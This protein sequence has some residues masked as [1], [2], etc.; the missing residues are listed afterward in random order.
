MGTG[1]T[2]LEQLVNCVLDCRDMRD[3]RRRRKEA[4]QIFIQRRS[5]GCR[6]LGPFANDHSDRSLPIYVPLLFMSLDRLFCEDFGLAPAF[7]GQM[8]EELGK[9][10]GTNSYSYSIYLTLPIAAYLWV[11]MWKH[12]HPEVTVPWDGGITDDVMRALGV[13]DNIQRVAQPDCTPPP[14]LFRLDYNVLFVA[15]NGGQIPHWVI[16]LPA[17]PDRAQLG[18]A[19]DDVQ[20]KTATA[21]APPPG[22]NVM[23]PADIARAANTAAAPPPLKAPPLNAPPRGP[24]PAIP[25]PVKS[26]PMPAKKPPPPPPRSDDEAFTAAGLHKAQAARGREPTMKAPPPCVVPR[27]SLSAALSRASSSAASAPAT[28]PMDRPTSSD[29]RWIENLPQ[30][31]TSRRPER[32]APT[33][34]R[35]SF[36]EFVRGP[37]SRNS[38]PA[39]SVTRVARALCETHTHKTCGSRPSRRRIGS[40]CPIQTRTAKR[41]RQKIKTCPQ[42]CGIIFCRPVIDM[43]QERIK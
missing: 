17:P 9:N 26:A 41:E 1:I 15:T 43:D 19:I 5:A 13:A 35:G 38:S 10:V 37:G 8:L 7:F 30:A 25:P 18:R 23:M 32:T 16:G 29:R 20:P 28:N 12:H 42:K 14:R 36:S 34:G 33:T 11:M 4:V 3:L 31:G 24:T 6:C 22:P 2:A 27:K 21:G 40:R 39:S